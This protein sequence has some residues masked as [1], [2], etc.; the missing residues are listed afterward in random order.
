[1][2]RSLKKRQF[3]LE[4]KNEKWFLRFKK[5]N[6]EGRKLVFKTWYRNV[7]ISP[8]MIG[9]S[10][11]IHNGKKFINREVTQ[12]MVGYKMGVFAPTRQ[13]GVHGK[14]GTH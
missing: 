9:H 5:A 3:T 11:L 14:A 1:M 2:S 13:P 8:E 12:D 4:L 6:E 10:L 7:V